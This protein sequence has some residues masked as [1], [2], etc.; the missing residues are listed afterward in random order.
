MRTDI[1]VGIFAL[2]VLAI[3]SYMTFKVGG[4][5]FLRKPGY[6]VYV[7]FKNVTGIDKKSR[8]RV[9]GV[10][11]GYVEDIELSDGRARLKL[12]INPNVKLYSDSTATIKTVGL[13]GERYLELGVGHTP[14][15]LEDGDTIKNVIEPV[16]VD[17]LMR[18]LASLSEDISSVMANVNKVLSPEQIEQFK[19]TVAAIRGLALNADTAVKVNDLKLRR[20][21]DDADRLIVRMDNLV[22]SNKDEVNELVANLKEFSDTLK[23]ESP[24]LFSDIRDTSKEIK[25]LVTET[26]PAI[27]NMVKKADKITSDIEEGKGTLGKLLK[28]ESLY[29]NL[30]G[31]AESVQTTLGAINRFRT[32]INFEGQYLSE[33]GDTKG[34]FFIT[35]QPKFDH[36]YI[37]G[38]TQDPVAKVEEETRIV[39][40]GTPVTTETIK[41]EIE[42]TAEFAKRFKNT[43]LRIGLIENTFG[44]G[45]DQY[46]K[47]DRGKIWVDAWD[48]SND[49]KDSHSP[50]VTAGMDYFLFKY[51][52]LSAGMDNVLNKRWRG[53]FVGGGLRF[54]DEDLKY[55][56]GSAPSIR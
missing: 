51:F 24:A 22:A 27:E 34:R 16:D 39:D 36:Y 8:V 20:A 52:Y 19:E 6:S 41:T 13:L 50:H 1:K 54:E 30:T 44:F 56:L 15:P 29:K 42:F 5:G 31:A 25:G 48:F 3:L 18:S 46:F 26:R 12:R 40:G 7:S 23:R 35:F 2:I 11:V 10:D 28:D 49:E 55:L 4:W 14:P 53:P 47:K 38:V 21:L 33:V 9:A 37:I 43:A 32:F 17:D 45:I